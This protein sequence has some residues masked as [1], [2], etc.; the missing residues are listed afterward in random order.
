MKTKAEK[1]EFKLN[2]TGWMPLIIITSGL[3]A[4]MVVIKILMKLLAH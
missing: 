3:I 4:L 1:K 2:K